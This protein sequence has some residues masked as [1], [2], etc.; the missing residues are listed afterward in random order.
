MSY[1]RGSEWRKWDLH[2]HSPESLVN[3]QYGVGGNDP[4]EQFLN[5]L[6]NLPPEFSVIGINDYIFIDGYRRV[7]NEKKRGR[8]SNIDLI[9]PVLEFRISQFSGAQDELSRINYH[10]IFTDIAEL[11]P[12]QIESQ[13]LNALSS[14]YKLEAGLNQSFW[15]GLITRASLSDLGKKVIESSPPEH[16]SSFP[17]HLTTG[18]NNLCL[19]KSE[20]EAILANSSYFKEKYFTAVGKAEWAKIKWTIQAAATKKN[21]L[22]SVDLVF[23]SIE[24]LKD[25]PRQKETLEKALVNSKLIDCSDAHSLSSSNLKDRIGNSFTWIK[26]DPTFKGLGHAIK[27]FEQRV[28]VGNSPPSAEYA[29]ING[30]KILKQVS[31]S[32]KKESS[33]KETW[34]NSNIPLNQSMIAIIGNKGS[35]KSALA[36]CIALAGNT[37]VTKSLSFLN[38]AKFRRKGKNNLASHYKVEIEWLSGNRTEA[39]LEKDPLPSSLEYVKYVP[40]NF[41]EEICNESGNS[42]RFENE[43]KAVIFSH[44]PQADKLGKGSLDELIKFKTDA[45]QSSIETERHKLSS[46]NVQIVDLE[47]QLMPDYKSKLEAYVLQKENELAAHKLKAPQPVAPPNVDSTES[48]TTDTLEDL[49]KEK[50]R[51]LGEISKTESSLGEVN[52]KIAIADLVLA[53]I[54]NFEKTSKDFLIQI[55]NELEQLGI[56]QSDILKIHTDTLKIKTVKQNQE[57]EKASLDL[58]MSGSGA[59]NLHSKLAELNKAINEAEHLL[60]LPA[61]MYQEYLKQQDAWRKQHDLIIGTKNINGSLIYLKEKLAAIDSVP[62]TLSK[63]RSQ[64]ESISVEIH[65]NLTDVLKIYEQY[66]QPVRAFTEGHTLLKDKIGMSFAVSLKLSNFE[67]SFFEFIARNVGGAFHGEKGILALQTLLQEHEWENTGDVIDFLTEV[68]TRLI[69]SDVINENYFAQFKKNSNVQDFYN[70]LYGLEYFSPQYKLRLNSKDLEQ[71][72][73]G[74]RGLLLLVFYLLIDKSESPLILDQPEENLDNQTVFQTLVPAIKEAKQRRQLILV[75]HN[76]NLA[77]VCDAEQVIYASLTEN[78]TAK[79]NYQYGSLENP[80]MNKKVIDILEGTRPAFDN[81][82]S[83]Y[84]KES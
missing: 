41:L 14:K 24:N 22:N 32:K 76:P 3:T 30:T 45:I 1:F 18:F 81:R 38:D 52:R 74:E 53:R 35:G 2:V 50:I 65:K 75:T 15:S 11:D 71:L 26:A 48:S 77:V 61:Q 43:L 47:R 40:Q 36:D 70:F 67:E 13:F 54:E 21:L 42:L 83:K 31:L 79:I 66:Y 34:F 55:A 23:S 29:K 49:Q 37:T 27:E 7:L 8:L 51:I 10:V 46:L 72:S 80:E 5:D 59:E 63:L 60:S 25:Y 56:L 73:P 20:I 17:S 64:R 84:H 33:H 44:V 6:E 82:D 9:L 12:D 57:K 78:G 28:F 19:E 62:G 16:Q 4:W 39:E 69:N 68:M 58:L